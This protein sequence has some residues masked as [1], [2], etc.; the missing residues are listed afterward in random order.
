[1]RLAL[2]SPVHGTSIEHIARQL[3][4][5]RVF[6]APF[7][8]RHYLHVSFG[9]N[10]NFE[11]DL[12]AFAA[13]EGHDIVFT[14]RRRLTWRYCTAN[15]L[16]ELINTAQSHPCDHDAVLIHTDA[17]LIFSKDIK[18]SI[19]SGLIHCGDKQFR[20]RT[21]WKWIERSL[22]DPRLQRFANLYFEGDFNKLRRGRICG[23]SMPWNIFE[24]FSKIYLSE[25]NDT[26]FESTIDTQWPLTEVSIPSILKIVMGE[27][28]QFMPPLI[29][30]PKKKH[31]T[32]RDISSAL[33]KGTSFGL[34]KIARDTNSEAFQYLMQ[35]QE[36][37]AQEN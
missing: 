27:D 20:I 14:K 16:S 34:K 26:Y 28:Y 11:T 36:Q 17:D 7:E 25:F 35:L 8:L 32:I 22:S 31:I 6:L 13:R 24:K 23:C 3:D 5:Y 10:E 2:L 29:S 4:N 18:Q 33:K 37:A 30:A 19:L 12:T 9:S 15:A 21:K 1:M